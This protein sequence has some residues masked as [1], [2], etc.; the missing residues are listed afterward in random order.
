M[1]RRFFLVG[2]DIASDRNRAKVAKIMEGF[3]YR[4]QYSL[5]EC[6]LD[7]RA[8]NRMLRAVA[9]HVTAGDGDS[10]RIYR[11]CEN[12]LQETRLLG[13]GP[14]PWARPEIIL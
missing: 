10:I 7:G 8:F 5:F 9:P 13:E 4:V 14:T 12:C 1:A 11:L 3:G 6:R 2:Y